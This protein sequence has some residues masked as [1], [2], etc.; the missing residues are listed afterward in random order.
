MTSLDLP[1]I[2]YEPNSYLTSNQVKDV[3]HKFCNNP[4]YEGKWFSK[5]KYEKL[6]KT[7]ETHLAA[8]KK[9]LKQIIKEYDGLVGKTMIAE[10]KALQAQI[11]KT[12]EGGNK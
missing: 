7:Y 12:T 5:I 6:Q 3:N 9:E 4:I 10:L 2:I 8:I 11:G 1:P